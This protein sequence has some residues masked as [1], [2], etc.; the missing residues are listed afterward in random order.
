MINVKRRNRPQ[1][2]SIALYLDY[3]TGTKRIQESTGLHLYP[4]KDDKTKQLNKENLI[5]FEILRCEKQ[6]QLLNGISTLPVNRNK[7]DFIKF[8]NQHFIKNPTKERRANAVL[9]QL[10]NFIKKPDLPITAINE[11]LLLRFKKHLESNLTGETPHNYFKLLGRVIKQAT[12]EGLFQVN[13]ISDI[14]IKKM[15][16]I[17][18]ETLTMEEIKILFQSDCSNEDVKRAF[19]FCCYTGL[20]YC[21]VSRLKWKNIQNDTFSLVQSKTKKSISNSI[22][23]NAFSLLGN[24]G[25]ELD[26]VFKLP[27]TLN[28]CNKVLKNWV[29]KSGINRKITWH[30]GRHSLATNLVVYKADILEVMHCMGHSSPA[31]TK[32]YIHKVE[33]MTKN[34]I[35]KLPVM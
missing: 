6:R 23:I 27:T 1:K 3:N 29:Y 35:N 15:E 32:R 30:C 21:D 10:L 33:E 16:G 25:N 2:G 5:R 14:K 26:L 28:G 31:H 22:H 18:K 20:R 34:A 17:D 4:E 11:D 19:L 12:K 7:I 24:R 9:N 13:P 8:Y